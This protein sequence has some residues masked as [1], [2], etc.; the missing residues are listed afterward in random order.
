M[1][2]IARAIERSQREREVGRTSVVVTHQSPQV[3]NGAALTPAVT[4]PNGVPISM[5]GAQ[6]GMISESPVISQPEQ[7][8]YKSHQITGS[9]QI[10]LGVLAMIFQLADILLVVN[11]KARFTRKLESRPTAPTSGYADVPFFNDILQPRIHVDGQRYDV[12]YA[13]ATY[14]SSFAAAFAGCGLWTGVVFVVAGMLGVMLSRAKE[15]EDRRMA[16]RNSYLV[17][18]ILA[19]T[20]FAPALTIAA[21][22]E[23]GRAAWYED[24]EVRMVCPWLLLITGLTELTVST[25]A[26]SFGCCC[27]RVPSFMGTVISNQ[28]TVTTCTYPQPAGPMQV[29]AAGYPPQPMVHTQLQVHPQPQDVAPPPYQPQVHGQETDQTIGWGYK[30]L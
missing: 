26:A 1:F 14:F 30:R 12:T 24:N 2:T 16:L 8:P 27:S 3:V 7:F 25:V 15:N 18:S 9:L 21:S 10:I 19:C 28:T 4:Q 5:V 29:I 22:V 17:L 11:L 13:E 20:M 23:L 6:S